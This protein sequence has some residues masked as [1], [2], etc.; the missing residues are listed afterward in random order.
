LWD[1][2]V[3][4]RADSYRP[5]ESDFAADGTHHAGPGMDKMGVLLLEFF[6]TDSAARPWFFRPKDA[7]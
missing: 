3:V 4:E 7:P 2:G 6:K 1:N 5:E